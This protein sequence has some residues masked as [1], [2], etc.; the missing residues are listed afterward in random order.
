MDQNK[1]S[2][3]I[4]KQRAKD[5]NLENIVVKLFQFNKNNLAEFIVEITKDVGKIDLGIGLHSCGSFTDLVM[6]LCR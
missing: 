1:T 5:G 2:L 6:E 4:L 3:D